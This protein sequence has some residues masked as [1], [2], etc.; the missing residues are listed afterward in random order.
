MWSSA[1]VAHPPQFRNTPHCVFRNAFLLA[2]VVKESD[3]IPVTSSLRLA[4]PIRPFPFDFSNQ[5][6]VST[7][8][9]GT[10]LMFFV[11]HTILLKLKRS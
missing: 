8:R 4:E 10:Y 1:V 9:T 7:H 6:V 11:C 3:D 2:T 5:Q